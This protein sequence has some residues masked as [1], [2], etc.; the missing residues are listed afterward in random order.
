M[1]KRLELLFSNED[2][3][4][5]TIGIDEP[6]EPVNPSAVAEVMDVIIA[7]NVF[8]SSKG[9]LIKKR[10]ARLVERTVDILDIEV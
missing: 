6:A 1:S 9:D 8:V 7:Q 5:V 4:S 2:G 10:G 3:A